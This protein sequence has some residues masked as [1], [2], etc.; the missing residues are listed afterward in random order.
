MLVASSEIPV[1]GVPHFDSQGAIRKL[2]T[3]RRE[4]TP[5]LHK[6][7]LHQRNRRH[8]VQWILSRV[9]HML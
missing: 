6:E 1:F 9:F 8:M 3:A 4:G 2:N 7:K 5:S